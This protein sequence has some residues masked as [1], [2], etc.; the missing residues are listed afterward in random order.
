MGMKKRNL[1]LRHVFAAMLWVFANTLLNAQETKNPNPDA[2]RLARNYLT[3]QQKTWHL[4]AADID[5][6]QLDYAYHTEH[7]GV[8][9]VFFIQS[10]NG[11]ALENALVN[12]NV[13]P[14]GS[15]LYAGNR[16]ITDLAAKVN[17]SRP[18]V[19]A[20]KALENAL[21]HLQKNYSNKLNVKEQKGTYDFVYRDE[22]LSAADVLVRLRYDLINAQPRLV[23]QVE[24]EPRGDADRWYVAIDA[25]SGAVATKRSMTIH[26]RVENNMFGAVQTDDCDP[27]STPSVAP[28][29]NAQNQRQNTALIGG[30]NYNVLPFPAE[31]PIHGTFRVLTDPADSLASPYGWHDTNGVMG[32]EHTITR[33]N[34]VNAYLDWQNT[35]T[36][37]EPQPDG[38][39]NLDFNFPYNNMLEPDSLR[40]LAQVNLFYANNAIHDITYRFGFNEVAGNFQ[41]N[42]YGRGGTGADFVIAEAQDGSRLATPNTNNANFA[43]PRDGQSGRM[44]MYVWTSTAQAGSPVKVTAPTGIAGDYE[45]TVAG[46]GGALPPVTAPIVG[47][48]ELVNDGSATPTYGCFALRNTTL[49]NKIALIDRGSCT[50]VEKVRFAQQKGARACL[51]CNFEN[52]LITMGGTAADITIPSVMLK[53]ADCDR[54]KAQLAAG[55]TV[56]LSAGIVPP[57][58]PTR[59]DGDFDNGI[60]AHE[61]GHGISNRLTGGPNNTSCLNNAE[62]MGE[63]WSDFIALALTAKPSDRANTSRGVGTFVQR[64]AT[65]GRGIRRYP[66]TSDMNTN[67]LTY[68][69]IV[70][71]PAVHDLGEVWSVTL[72]D[73]YW[74][75]VDLYGW[76]ADLTNMNSGNAKAIK[77]VMDG[78]KIQPCTPGFLDGRNAILA[79]DRANFAGQN[80]CLIWDVFARRGLGYY[81]KQGASTSTSDNEEN[82]DKNPY[83]VK[84]LKIEKTAPDTANPNDVV[85][86]TLRVMNH[87]TTAATNVVVTDE[88]PSGASF[89]AGSASNG[90]TLNGNLVTYNIANMASLDTVVLTYR[91]NVGTRRSTAFF[92]DGMENGDANWDIN[93]GTGTTGIWELS[94]A[95]G[96][97][98]GRG[99]WEVGSG[100]TAKTDARFFNMNQLVVTGAKPVLR[101]FQNYNTEGGFDGGMIEISTN[102][103][104]TWQDLGSKIFRLPYNNK[105]NYQTLV[106]PNLSCFGGASNGY[107]ASYVDL[108]SYAGQNVKLRWRFAADSTQPTGFGASFWQV[109]EIMLMDMVNHDTR[110]RLT[111]A[112]GDTASAVVAGRGI[113][114]NPLATVSNEDFGTMGVRIYPNP[115]YDFININI[116]GAQTDHAQVTV[117]DAAG[118]QIETMKVGLASGR[119]LL[120]LSTSAWASGVYFI[121]VKTAQEVK[122]QKVIKQ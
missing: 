41:Q 121:Q 27:L 24:V 66:Y 122:V 22:V 31:S 72:W 116:E 48:V 111:S 13:M 95:G 96:S 115:T 78:M 47:T 54:I 58:G 46:F 16:F 44:Q 71:N 53:K 73:L 74:A 112:Q 30:G 7:N 70:S 88:I 20:Q 113:V 67:P 14:D 1:A 33:G 120:P 60:I 49:T 5:N 104:T 86:I 6:A 40:K 17:A 56:S 68:G 18:T 12:V 32:A 52:A 101:F 100:T 50:F 25:V 81:A 43:T 98:R 62:Q 108:S 82:F 2:V 28:L 51:V 69:D 39:A 19:S 45:A 93:T 117:T 15:I 23:W 75:F 77:L 4:T 57:A 105:L 119:T 103:G 21:L 109:D 11:I 110:A 102:N 87:K 76:N 55:V 35:S 97:Y 118:R 92:Y 107:K 80:E 90:G 85:T 8:T 9:H 91:L 84:T 38:G 99:M 106:I 94:T 65:T 64:Q 37:S 79:A 36:P 29:S 114:I 42:N 26:C 63:G 3:A 59:L 89:V 10:H 83:C 61:Y 34:N